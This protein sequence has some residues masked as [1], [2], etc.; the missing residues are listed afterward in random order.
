M[1]KKLH[2]PSR[3]LPFTDSERFMETLLS[4]LVDNLATEI[5]IFKRKYGHDHRK[6]ETCGFKCKGCGSCLEHTN[7]KDNLI[8]YK[9]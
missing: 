6:C 5:D 7:L 4:N 2:K 8:I 9:C 3:T 1:E